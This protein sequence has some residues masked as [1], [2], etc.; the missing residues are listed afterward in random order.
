LAGLFGS[1]SSARPPRLLSSSVAAEEPFSRPLDSNNKPR[2]LGAPSSLHPPPLSFQPFP[3]F[4]FSVQGTRYRGFSFTFFFA[5]SSASRTGQDCPFFTIAAGVSLSTS[6]FYPL[7]R[8]G[9]FFFSSS[10]SRIPGAFPRFTLALP[11]FFRVLPLQGETRLF[12]PAFPTL[13]LNTI[14]F[15]LPPPFPD[16]LWPGPPPSGTLRIIFFR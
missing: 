2:F 10:L 12:L 11:F 15:P 8:A 1:A 16:I 5:D 6:A 7:F 9:I 3:L 4:F 14:I 13:H